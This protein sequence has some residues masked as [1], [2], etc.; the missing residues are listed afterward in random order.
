MTGS[1]SGSDV[2]AD[3]SAAL[4]ASEISNS[5]Q[6]E[7]VAA[8]SFGFLDSW[9]GPEPLKAENGLADSVREMAE[10]LDT[11]ASD[12]GAAVSE[13]YET[14]NRKYPDPMGKT[15][16][17]STPEGRLEALNSLTQETATGDFENQKAE[18]EGRKE[19]N[20]EKHM[21][22][23]T[24]LLAGAMT[25]GGTDGLKVVLEMAQNGADKMDAFFLQ[26]IQKKL[27]SGE[28]ITDS[29]LQNLKSGLHNRLRR[30]QAKFR[31]EN[32]ITTPDDGGVDGQVMQNAFDGNADLAKLYE[33]NGM[34]VSFIDHTADG[35]DSANHFVLRMEGEDGKASYYNPMA[36]KG[37]QQVVTDADQVAMYEAAEHHRFGPGGHQS[38]R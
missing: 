33:D 23:A 8:S 16:D 17:L 9:F 36:L 32:G 30:D 19:A 24:T 15:L 35:K 25:A 4:Q 22:G 28:A 34:S 26:G 5:F 10:K 6:A 18:D 13:T 37:G 38:M 31:E 1:G 20:A 14:D 7:Q 29:D 3:V 21:C 27:E 2:S 11:A 12:P